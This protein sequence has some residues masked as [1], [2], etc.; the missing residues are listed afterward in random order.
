M[1]N[2][3]R[4]TWNDVGRPGI[5]SNRMHQGSWDSPQMKQPPDLTGKPAAW[6]FGSSPISSSTSKVEAIIDSPMW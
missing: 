6:I 5:S 3:S 4:F 1:S 2:T